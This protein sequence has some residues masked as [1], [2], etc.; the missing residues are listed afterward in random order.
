MWCVQV[1]SAFR[2]FDLSQPS[3]FCVDTIRTCGLSAT[4]LANI[5][6]NNH[7]YPN[8]KRIVYTHG[9][10]KLKVNIIITI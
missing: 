6:F 3:L 10:V 8:S 1:K 7:I 5:G 2:T 4:H 9:T